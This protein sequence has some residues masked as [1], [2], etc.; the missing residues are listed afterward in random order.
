MAH[1]LIH[2]GEKRALFRISVCT[3][4]VIALLVGL[5]APGYGWAGEIYRLHVDMDGD[6]KPETVQ[7]LTLPAPQDWRS[8]VIVKVGVATYSTEFFSIDSDLPDIQVV[9]IDRG[10]RQRQL[11]IDAPEAGTCTYHLLSFDGH[12]LISLLKFSSGPDCKAPQALGDGQVS[13]STWQGFW[14]KEDRYRLSNDGK[15]LTQERSSTYAVGVAGA[16]SRSFLLQGAECAA[17]WVQPGTY[18]KVK[19]YEP[20]SDRYRLETIAGG[21]GWISSADMSGMGSP[22]RELP[23]AG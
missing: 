19:L 2:G 14:S 18:V 20:D 21:C 7:V 11:L 8:R 4:I 9:W 16:A 6:G 22:I 13:V 17:S 15:V 12:R 1:L 5:I 23:W 3:R 10:R